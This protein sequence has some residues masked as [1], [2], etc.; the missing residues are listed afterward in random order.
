V[1]FVAPNS[2][3]RSAGFKVGDKI[4]LINGKPAQAWPQ[5]TLANLKYGAIGTTL[6]FTMEGGGLR[7]VKLADYF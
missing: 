6:A 4:A 7:Q 3:A 1:G 5:T 2:P